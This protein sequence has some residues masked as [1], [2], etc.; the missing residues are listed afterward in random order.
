MSCFYVKFFRLWLIFTIAFSCYL[1][2]EINTQLT[3]QLFR[4]SENAVMEQN[5]TFSEGANTTF[6][7]WYDIKE[8]G[9]WMSSP[10]HN[11]TK[12][13][14][15]SALGIEEKQFHRLTCMDK[16]DNI[17]GQPALYRDPD[18]VVYDGDGGEC[19]FDAQ[20]VVETESGD[21][22]TNNSPWP[23]A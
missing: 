3:R 22:R 1:R 2:V 19:T 23:T 7:L 16:L 11:C 10:A 15:A 9:T 14:N 17:D 5:A 8:V 6:D 18:P 21:M 20:T 4:D 12:V 13:V